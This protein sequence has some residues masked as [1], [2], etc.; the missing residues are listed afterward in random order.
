MNPTE[1]STTQVSQQYTYTST[2]AL[3]SSIPNP[4]AVRHLSL[5]YTLSF[6]QLQLPPSRIYF[7]HLCFVLL[8]AKTTTSLTKNLFYGRSHRTISCSGRRKVLKSGGRG[9]ISNPS[10]FE[11][12]DLAYFVR[13][14][15]ILSPRSDGPV[16]SSYSLDQQTQHNSLKLQTQLE[17]QSNCRKTVQKEFQND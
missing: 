2:L 13:A 10:H 6:P 17:R 9:A 8:A 4:S 11:G 1:I 7:Q 5:Q 3:Y 14:I 12:Q 16:A 15:A